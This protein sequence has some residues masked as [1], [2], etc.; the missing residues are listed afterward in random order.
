MFSKI[1]VNNFSER[2]IIEG[3]LKEEQRR[4]AD[5]MARI[6]KVNHKLE[7]IS[8]CTENLFKD[9]GKSQ[10]GNCRKEAFGDGDFCPKNGVHADLAT[11]LI[12]EE[13]EY[14]RCPT[15][16]DTVHVTQDV[17]INAAVSTGETD[18]PSNTQEVDV[19][20]GA[21]GEVETQESDSTRLNENK[22]STQ[23]AVSTNFRAEEMTGAT[24][25]VISTSNA[26]ISNAQANIT[27]DGDSQTNKQLDAEQIL[28]EYLPR[29]DS[30]DIEIIE[31]YV[32]TSDEVNTTA[33]ED[34][35]L[36]I[37]NQ[38][39]SVQ[40][41]E[42]YDERQ[43][44]V[45]ESYQNQPIT[46]DIEGVN[47]RDEQSG[48]SD[49]N[50]ETIE[51]YAVA[52]DVESTTTDED[53]S[54]VMDNQQVSAQNAEA[55]DEIQS[56]VSESYQNQ[57]IS[58]DLE[59]VNPRDELISPSGTDTQTI[60]T[61]AAAGDVE[62]TTANEDSS[63]VM[64]DQQVSAQN[65][66]AYDEIQSHVSESYQNQPISED[67][68]GVNPR[69][70]LIS[71]SGTDTQTIETDA[72]A[73]D[74]ES[75]TAN[76]DSSAVMDDQQISTQNAEAYDEIQSHVSESYQNQPI[77][78]D[79]EGVNPRDEL[80][81]PSGTDTVT[82]DTGAVA[83]H[84]EN[85]TANEDTIAV[86]DNQHDS[87]QNAEAYDERQNHVSESYQ[88]QPIS[89]DLEGVNPREEQTSPPDDVSESLVP[90]NAS[91]AGQGDQIMVYEE[92]PMVDN[93]TPEEMKDF[94]AGSKASNNLS[95]RPTRVSQLPKP[96]P[97]KNKVAS[98][99]LESEQPQRV[100]V[101]RNM[102]MGTNTRLNGN[103]Q[104]YHYNTD[105]GGW[106]P[107]VQGMHG[108]QLFTLHQAQQQDEFY[109]IQNGIQQA[110]FQRQRG[111]DGF[112]RDWDQE[113]SFQ[114]GP[115][116]HNKYNGVNGRLDR[117]R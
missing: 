6:D 37:D 103:R 24:N 69:D 72:A 112:T 83:S 17:N 50:I 10:L 86:M 68:E 73:G 3:K 87:A 9:Q 97:V 41:E 117:W 26:D 90:V 16:T 105:M 36:V 43:S 78:E 53:T 27:I 84:V 8:V 4:Y 77:S 107:Y 93:Q 21:M 115:G 109:R 62:S 39:V 2:D 94:D 58:E 100:N 82:I 111:T 40:N 110:S 88:N 108:M 96:K 7:A 65:A 106:A 67:L 22:V 45:S 12:T 23:I 44:H 56:H 70:E 99:K 71:P 101:D 85:T 18:T 113:Q 91:K 49:S 5:L 63:A 89:E 38:Q 33:N 59:G 30:E 80:I 75:T 20:E 19:A 42:A 66:E 31:T 60:E 55:Y 102:N 79:I 14:K 54:A 46:E 11:N 64:D 104:F 35:S 74:V 1:A 48:P 47:P 76:E 81:S 32:A 57:P 13:T 114:R 61:D 52:S 95:E 34:T 98:R 51:T 92:V 15:A 28:E 116:W 29:I 25:G